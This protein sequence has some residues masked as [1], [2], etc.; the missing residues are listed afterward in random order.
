MPITIA[1]NP[2]SSAATSIG[3]FFTTSP[4]SP[5]KSSALPIN[6]ATNRHRFGRCGATIPAINRS[7]NQK[8]VS[9]NKTPINTLTPASGA[10][11]TKPPAV[12]IKPQAALFIQ[13]DRVLV[14]GF[15]PPLK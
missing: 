2:T 10:K 5:N 8:L 7:S 15:A 4:K 1:D 6:F 11:K 3:N 12:K 13:I 9:D 14:K